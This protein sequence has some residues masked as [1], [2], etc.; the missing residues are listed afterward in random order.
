ML[1]GKKVNTGTVAPKRTT[2][3]QD[4]TQL[5][6]SVLDPSPFSLQDFPFMLPNAPQ[7]FS[8]L[9]TALTLKQC[10]QQ[11]RSSNEC[12]WLRFEI[13]NN[14]C[15]QYDM[16]F[17]SADATTPTGSRVYERVLFDPSVAPSSSAAVVAPS[18]TP[19]VVPSSSIPVA[20]SST[21]PL[22]PFSCGKPILPGIDNGY[23]LADSF[24]DLSECRAWCLSDVQCRYLVYYDTGCYVYITKL[25]W[26]G[27]LLNLQGG[28]FYEMSCF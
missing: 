27:G 28:M 25:G 5:S 10:A 26:S 19:V 8:F 18:S 15:Y 9:T 6:G 17:V 16:P 21:P 20:A 1:T 13:T 23:Y 12:K 11:C 14:L 7:R 22:P 4:A 3:Q 24:N 2:A